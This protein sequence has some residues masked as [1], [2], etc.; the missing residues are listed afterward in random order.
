MPPNH[1]ELE[2]FVKYSKFFGDQQISTKEIYSNQDPE[3]NNMLIEEA[4][5]ELTDEGLN[6]VSGTDFYLG[7]VD[8]M[9]EEVDGEKTYRIIETNGGSSR[10]ISSLPKDQWN[11]CNKA[12]LET[13]SAWDDGIVLIGHPPKDK[14][15]YEKAFLTEEFMSH[16]L[17]Y[18][19]S[20]ELTSNPGVVL[21]SYDE[22]IPRLSV[23]NKKPMLDGHP[24]DVIIGDGVVRRHPVLTEKTIENEL[25]AVVVNKVFPVTDDKSATYKAQIIA[26]EELRKANVKPIDFTRA[27]NKEEIITEVNERIKKHGSAIIKPSR[28]SGGRGIEIIQKKNKVREKVEQSLSEFGENFKFHENPYPYTVSE[29]IDSK[30]IK[31]QDTYRNFDMRV[32]VARAGNKLKPVGGLVRVAL[33]PRSQEYKKPSIVVNL[34]GYE[35]IDMHRGLAINQ[36]TLNKLDTT[37]NEFK[38]IYKSAVIMFSVI[39]KN[40]N[41]LIKYAITQPK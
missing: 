9:M 21:D 6:K 17:D 28:G 1:E 34:S 11:F 18:Y 40:Q 38:D 33:E 10:G 5:E 24:V 35:G 32:Y 26:E 8:F 36:K 13:L 12:Y 22:I 3:L 14:M 20:K 30:P 37:P 15:L 29:L 19:R 2:N 31:Y 27:Y 25:D 4:S 7:C 41:K 16:G 39:L 23:E